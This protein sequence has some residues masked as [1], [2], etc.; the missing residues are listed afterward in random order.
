MSSFSCLE[1]SR[2]VLTIFLRTSLVSVVSLSLLMIFFEANSISLS[3]EG[4]ELS[5]VK[6]RFNHFQS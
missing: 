1:K 6:F 5:L 3:E 2:K 4:T